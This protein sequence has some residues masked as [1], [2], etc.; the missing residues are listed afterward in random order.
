MGSGM[1]AEGLAFDQSKASSSIV[2]EERV[3]HM[4]TDVG[5]C[6]EGV[7]TSCGNSLLFLC[8]P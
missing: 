8:L 6:G 3:E 4:Q 2:S 7:V 5:R 1:Q